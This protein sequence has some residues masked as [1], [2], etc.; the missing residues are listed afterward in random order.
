MTVGSEANPQCGD[1]LAQLPTREA[2]EHVRVGRAGT[3]RI[4]HV[5]AGLP[6]M[7]VPTHPS[8]IPV[9]SK[10]LCSRAASRWRSLIC[11]LR[12]RVRFLSVRIDVGGTK[13]APS[14]PASSSWQS[15]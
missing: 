10:I 2:G 15:H 4:K 5:P 7:S 14:S 1:L 8:L 12:Y 9:S 11:V 3:G 13:L 6:R